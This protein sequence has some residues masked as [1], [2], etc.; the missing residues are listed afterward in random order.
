MRRFRKGRLPL[1]TQGKCLS[2]ETIWWNVKKTV[3][4]PDWQRCTLSC[5]RLHCDANRRAS[6]SQCDAESVGRTSKNPKQ[7]RSFRQTIQRNLKRTKDVNW[8]NQSVSQSAFTVWFIC[9]EHI[10]IQLDVRLRYET[11]SC[12]RRALTIAVWMS[13]IH[14]AFSVSE[15]AATTRHRLPAVHTEKLLATATLGRVLSSIWKRRSATKGRLA[16]KSSIKTL[17][18][19]QKQYKNPL[20][21]TAHNSGS[22]DLS[23]SVCLS[24][25][26]KSD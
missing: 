20:K 3:N 1:E 9:A 5:W 24:T 22:I 23:L 18:A 19:S 17:K 2:P 13:S 11:S 25:F 4:W 12:D 7:L 26:P 14:L 8:D 6:G 16:P 15:L 10:Y 21:T